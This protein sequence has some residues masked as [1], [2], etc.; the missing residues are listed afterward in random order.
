MI[1]VLGEYSVSGGVEEQNNRQ[2]QQSKVLFPRNC[3][4][5]GEKERAEQ[6]R[7]VCGCPLSV[8]EKG[9]FEQR[10]EVREL[11]ILLHLKTHQRAPTWL[12]GDANPDNQ[13]L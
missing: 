6:V 8:I 4:M 3:S 9:R 5:P 10:L 1:P 13:S 2:T 11:V 7:R 12:S